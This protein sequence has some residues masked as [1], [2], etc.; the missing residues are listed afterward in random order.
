MRVSDAHL[1]EL[2]KIERRLGV[3]RSALIQMA[4]AEYI[5]KMKPSK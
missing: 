1:A 3:Q 5:E 2:A 4:I